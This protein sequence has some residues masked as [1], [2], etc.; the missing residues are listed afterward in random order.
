MCTAA[1]LGVATCPCSG[2]VSDDE[3]AALVALVERGLQGEPHL[4]FEPLEARMRRL[5][6]EDRYEEAAMTRDRLAALARALRRRDN[7]DAVRVPAR[8][9]LTRRDATT[10]SVTRVELQHG[11][12]LIEAGPGNSNHVAAPDLSAPPAFDEVDEL[13]IVARF[14][15]REARRW[16][17][18]SADGGAFAWRLP[19]VASYEPVART[20]PAS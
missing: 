1:Q 3:Y 18:A 6:E 10:G 20:A 19:R 15:E 14:V 12:L 16:R 5:A 11:R 8:L 17:V 13:L 2:A 9:E 4:L 7:L